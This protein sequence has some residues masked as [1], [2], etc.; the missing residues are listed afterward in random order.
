[1]FS[2]EVLISKFEL[3]LEHTKQI[4]E[5]TLSILRPQDYVNSKQGVV[6]FDSTLMRLQA[7]GENLKKIQTV[8]PEILKSKSEIDWD[9][10]IRLRDIISHHY[11]KL[12]E[13]VV[14]DICTVFIPELEKAVNTILDELRKS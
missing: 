5:N 7:I 13:E 14:F 8:H 9:N 12:Q 6:L 3:V 4:N 2:K 10:I 1:M 11:E